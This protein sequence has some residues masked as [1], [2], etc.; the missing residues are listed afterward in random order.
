MRVFFHEAGSATDR[1]LKE[2]KEKSPQPKS[3]GE[4]SGVAISKLLLT[5]EFK[6]GLVKTRGVSVGV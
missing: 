1:V 6:V 3:R 4:L 5:E 2:V